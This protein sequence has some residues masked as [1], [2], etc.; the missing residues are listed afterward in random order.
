MTKFIT[1]L[2]LLLS[3]QA[4]SQ[5]LH[6]DFHTYTYQYQDSLIQSDRTKVI[7][8]EAWQADEE[9]KAKMLLTLNK[10]GLEVFNIWGDTILGGDYTE[11]GGDY[12]I[13]DYEVYL[14]DGKAALFSATTVNKAVYYGDDYCD[15]DYF[16][17]HEQWNQECLDKNSGE[18]RE[19]F[20]VDTQG[21]NTW[22]PSND[23]A[24]FIF[25]SGRSQF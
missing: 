23:L 20:F 14:V 6:P 25:D 22:L 4:F 16:D 3:I 5:E 18:L 21:S 9:L 17:V 19:K 12:W 8:F 10:E 24:N 1:S 13:A 15:Y 2:F 7:S 11:L